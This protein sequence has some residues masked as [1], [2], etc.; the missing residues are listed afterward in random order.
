MRTLFGRGPDGV[1]VHRY[2]IGSGLLELELLDLGAAL[3]RLHVACP[4]GIR[5]NVVLGYPD[6]EGRLAS[7]AYIGSTIGRVANRIGGGRFPLDGTEY[8]VAANDGP[9]TRHGG[10][11]GFDRRLWTV[12]EHTPSSVVFGLESPDG[13]QGF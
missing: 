3:H 7:T 8:R 13:D 11:D 4:D 10:P 5:R 6:V 12:L 2:T 9:N 1:P